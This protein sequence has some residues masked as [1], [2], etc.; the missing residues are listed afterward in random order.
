M[1][2]SDLGSK[3]KGL[4]VRHKFTGDCVW[5]IK[6]IYVS[7]KEATIEFVS[8]EYSSYSIG[9]I[10]SCDL[11]NL[12]LLDARSNKEASAFLRKKNHYL[13]R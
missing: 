1:E 4:L 8:G 10:S 9:D 13:S 11:V 5:K 2:I 7:K 3:A 6:K 12:I